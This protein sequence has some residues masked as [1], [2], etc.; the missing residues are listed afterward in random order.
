[1]ALKAADWDTGATK[2]GKME[3][4]QMQCPLKHYSHS[5]SGPYD[6][7]DTNWLPAWKIIR[8][9]GR[10][11][12]VLI[13]DEDKISSL[14]FDKLE[15]VEHT[16]CEGMKDIVD[17]LSKVRQ[18]VDHVSLDADKHVNSAVIPDETKRSAFLQITN[19]TD[20]YTMPTV[21]DKVR[22]SAE[23]V[24]EID[25]IAEEAQTT[26]KGNQLLNQ[27][28]DRYIRLVLCCNK[29]KFNPAQKNAQ[30]VSM[31]IFID[32]IFTAKATENWTYAASSEERPRKAIKIED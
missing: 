16:V 4:N 26:K 6:Y 29:C 3:Q 14:L 8:Q 20:I 23:H 1:M 11:D 15:E 9:V 5:G 7:I 28:Q 2:V 10:G 13:N 12:R 22:E 32:Q 18:D 30:Y 19:N 24:N 27:M 25:H 21:E 17:S 31:P